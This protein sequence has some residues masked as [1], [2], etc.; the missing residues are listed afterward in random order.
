MS[1]FDEVN[2]RHAAAAD[3]ESRQAVDWQRNLE[4]HNRV[5]ATL[6]RDFAQSAQRLQIEPT[7]QTSGG[8][9]Y[10]RGWYVASIV[11][12]HYSGSEYGKWHGILID[13]DGRWGWAEPVDGVDRDFVRLVK[14]PER[15]LTEPVD[16]NRMRQQLI[17]QL[18]KLSLRG[19]K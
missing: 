15:G 2:K 16:Q 8:A 3:A 18:E 12:T 9:P 7:E 6:A 1:M 4:A 13:A 17:N 14:A 10:M 5:M 11:E 19:C